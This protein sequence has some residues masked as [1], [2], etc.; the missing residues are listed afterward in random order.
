M[1]EIMFKGIDVKVRGSLYIPTFQTLK[2]IQ[3]IDYNIDL[4]MTLAT[5]HIVVATFE[6][7]GLPCT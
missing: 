3:V 6:G 5:F 2:S 7:V 4:V 1:S